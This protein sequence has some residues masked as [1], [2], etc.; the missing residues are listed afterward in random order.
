MFQ[1]IQSISIDAAAGVSTGTA[2]VP[3]DHPLFADHFPGT[4]LLSG[5][6]LIELAAQIAGPLAEQVSKLRLDVE[7]WSLLGMIRN[8]RFLR[9]VPLPATIVFNA[10]VRRFDSSSIALAVDAHEGGQ[11][12]MRAELVMMLFEAAPEWDA[13]IRARHQ[14]LASWKG[15]AGA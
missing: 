3:A 9:P 5:S 1:L 14:R 7:R 13:A 4:P 6:L 8:A 12:V 11:L 15:V 10:E 2:I